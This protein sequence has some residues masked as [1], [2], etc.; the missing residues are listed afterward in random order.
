[1]ATIKDEQNLSARG[2]AKMIGVHH[3]TVDRLLRNV[4]S[5]EYVPSAKT[6]LGAAKAF[7]VPVPTLIRYKVT[8]RKDRMASV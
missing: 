5:D 2:L 4:D 8:T 7:R 6:L 1:M 3:N